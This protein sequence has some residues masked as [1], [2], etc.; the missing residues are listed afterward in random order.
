MPRET[1]LAEGLHPEGLTP[2]QEEL[3]LSLF[4][5]GAILFDFEP[6]GGWLLKH[7]E[8]F[9]EAPRSPL[10]IDL[11]KLQSCLDA[12]QSAISALVE[13]A[14]GLEYDYIAGIPLAAIALASSMADRVGK[15]QI[16]PRIDK[17]GH[18]TGVKIDGSYEE[19]GVALVLDDLVTM[20][21]SKLEAIKTIEAGGLMVR[22]VVVVF[23]RQQGGAEELAER[24]YTLHPALEIRPTLKFYARMGKISQ[25][26]LALTLGYLDN[27]LGE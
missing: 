1:V 5:V 14:E 18:G 2:A 23:D 17:K 4:D 7:H 13:Q 11:R 8:R 26:E 12:K 15:P 27:P 3:A 19:G 21:A 24:G 25:E 20:G 9:P 16:T 6:G 22:D 10:Y